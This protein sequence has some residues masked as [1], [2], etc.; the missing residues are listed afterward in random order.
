[1]PDFWCVRRKVLLPQRRLL[2]RRHDF[3]KAHQLPAPYTFSSTLSAGSWALCAF[4]STVLARSQALP[5]PFHQR[6]RALVGFFCCLSYGHVKVLQ[7]GSLTQH[8]GTA[9]NLSS[10]LFPRLYLHS[11]VFLFTYVV[12]FS[13]SLFQLFIVHCTVSLS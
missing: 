9:A 6:C 12:I 4:S 13:I 8:L 11:L 2:F 7:S 5:A 3:V 1:M 10:M